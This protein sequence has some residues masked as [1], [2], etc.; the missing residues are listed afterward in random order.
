ME[1]NEESKVDKKDLNLDTQK[2][3]FIILRNLIMLGFNNRS[4]YQKM[5]M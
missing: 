4:N 1:S 5:R 3:R 2:V